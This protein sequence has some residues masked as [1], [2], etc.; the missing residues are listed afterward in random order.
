MRDMREFEEHP[1]K[2]KKEKKEKSYALMLRM[3]VQRP[4]SLA[5]VSRTIAE[6]RAAMFC[7]TCAQ[8]YRVSTKTRM[9]WCQRHHTFAISA[10]IQSLKLIL[11]A[12]A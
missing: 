8:S 1:R 10:S 9:S 7:N 12:C 2:K 6:Q 11:I 3:R 5:R 4:T